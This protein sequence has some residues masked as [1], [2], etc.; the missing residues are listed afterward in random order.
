MKRLIKLSVFLL[1][2]LILVSPLSAQFGRN[3][4]HWNAPKREW[5]TLKGPNVDVLYYRGAKNVASILLE[6]AESSYDTLKTL[7]GVEPK[8]RPVIVNYVTGHVVE[9]NIYP[10]FIPGNVAGFFEN[11]K[12]RIVVPFSGNYHWFRCVVRHELAHRFQTAVLRKY[13]SNDWLPDV[14]GLRMPLWWTEGLAEYWAGDHETCRGI[15]REILLRDIVVSG[16]LNSF[17]VERLTYMGGFTP[18]LFGFEL[19]RYLGERFGDSLAVKVYE[20]MSKHNN[21]ENLIKDVYGI[22]FRRLTIGFHDKLRKRYMPQYSQESSPPNMNSEL[23][24]PSLKGV[25]VSGTYKKDSTEYIL[26]SSGYSGYPTLYRIAVFSDSLENRHEPD[27]LTDAVVVKCDDVLDCELPLDKLI[28]VLVRGGRRGYENINPWVDIHDGRLMVMVARDKQ[29][30]VIVVRNIEENEEIERYR[31]ESLPVLGSPSWGPNG[32]RTAFSGSLFHPDSANS[33]VSDLYIFNTETKEL[34]RLTNDV[35]YDGNPKWSPDGRWILFE[36]DR[37]EFGSKGYV[38]LFLLSPETGR[39]FYLTH[40]KWRDYQAS[41]SE[42][43]TEVIFVSDRSQ[44]DGP[45]GYEGAKYDIYTVNVS[46]ENYGKVYRLTNYFGSAFSPQLV[47][48]DSVIVFNGYYGGR[49]VPYIR[50]RPLAIDSSVLDLEDPV[51]QPTWSWEMVDL[52]S[53]QIS[54]EPHHSKFSLV[55]GFA[56]VGI[57]AGHGSILGGG[58][59]LTD[60]FDDQY[61]VAS[62]GVSSYSYLP[63]YNRFGSSLSYI[64]FRNRFNYSVSLF[65]QKGPLIDIPRRHIYESKTFGASFVGHY[66]FSLYDR[67][68]LWSSFVFLKQNGI[69][70]WSFEDDLQATPDSINFDAKGLISSVG[71]AL[72]GDNTLWLPTGPVAGTRYR[73]S[74]GASVNASSLV[75]SWQGSGSLDNV[76]SEGILHNYILYADF[77][78]Y[79]RFARRGTYAIRTSGFLSGGK[80]PTRISVSKLGGMAAFYPWHTPY[81]SRIF[82]IHQRLS[83]PFVDNISMTMPALGRLAM[84]GIQGSLFIDAAWVSLEDR[85]GIVWGDY[86]FGLRIPTP[87]RGVVLRLDWGK[88]FTARKGYELPERYRGMKFGWWIGYEF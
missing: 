47:S 16:Y 10:G 45:F 22:D 69:R 64:N 54:Q 15:D 87:M 58:V 24:A 78:H 55:N 2:F 37:T 86:G 40:G 50:E 62:F 41:W 72:A 43:G 68:E 79:F 11:V 46:G 19:H 63:N 70:S 66:P 4:V 80:V 21:F 35:Y 31:F 85:R 67:L 88:I 9:T 73:L 71:F 74:A 76:G 75:N 53:D 59:I 8:K 51:W 36:S 17:T 57:A 56:S 61:L 12:D 60:D 81:G 44:Y 39:I 5:M 30:D 28:H 48:G 83:I 77:R 1:G 13:E 42:D 38:N 65:G 18:Y 26:A 7:F 23:F 49:N 33:G 3:K 29:S 27:T 6:Y 34:E 84:G 52:S 82:A 20:K 32:K 25:F 14:G